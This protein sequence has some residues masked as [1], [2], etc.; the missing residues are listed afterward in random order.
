MSTRLVVAGS[1]QS[2]DVIEGESFLDA[3]LRHGVSVRYGCRQGKCSTCKHTVVDGSYDDR[4]VSAYAL[5]DDERDRGLTLLCQAYPLSDC[6]IQFATADT[7][8]GFVKR[9]IPVTL[10]ARLVRADRVTP[11]IRRVSIELAGRMR[12]LAGQYLEVE[13]PSG[14][15]VA[16]TLSIA[17]GPSDT[18]RFELLV[19]EWDGGAV[20]SRLGELPPGSP[21][22]IS[23][24]YGNMFFR[25]SDRP[26]ILIGDG[27]GIAPLLSIV[28]AIGQHL[29]GNSVRIFHKADAVDELACRDELESFADRDPRHVYQP[30]V[31]SLPIDNTGPV[32]G[33][34]LTTRLVRDIEPGELADIYVAGSAEFCDQVQFVL[35]ARG[36]DS[37]RLFIERFYPS[38]SGRAA[39]ASVGIRHNQSSS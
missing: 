28:R 18:Q 7:S 31:P 39:G 3:L 36:L 5:L 35:E 17:S 14:S 4:N 1:G 10:E 34:K 30:V 33:G 9:P 26:I 12:F 27:V 22:R 6:T 24:P 11:S 38:S 2:M 16:R 20:S 8:L 19:Q 32:A 15:G 25:P 29:H 37:E 21:V 23:G 13:V